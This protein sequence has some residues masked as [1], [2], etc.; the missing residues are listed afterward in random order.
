[1]SKENLDRFIDFVSIFHPSFQYTFSATVS[2]VSVN[3][4]DIK[5]CVKVDEIYTS[6]YCKETDP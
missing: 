3:F 4:L 6:V 2:E 5:L 1:M